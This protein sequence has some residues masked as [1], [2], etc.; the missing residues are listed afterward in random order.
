[1]AR[2]MWGGLRLA[3]IP[4]LSFVPVCR[5]H[6]AVPAAVRSRRLGIDNGSKYWDKFYKHHQNKFFKDR[7]YLEKDWGQYF[8]CDDENTTLPHGKV[9][10]EVGCGAGNTIFP[11]VARYPKLFV[12][13]CDFSTHAIKLLTSHVDFNEEQVNAFVCD[14]VEDDLCDKVMPSSV[15]VATLIFMLSA[16][17]PKKMHMILQNIRKVLKPEGYILVR[18]YAIGDY[19]QMELQKRNQLISENFYVRGDGTCAYFFSED[20]LSALFASVGFSIINMEIYSRKIQNR[21]QNVTM[22]R[23]WIRAAFGQVGNGVLQ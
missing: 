18:D 2:E 13:A 22:S 12:H 4:E 21:S 7:H 15:D 6:S 16:V 8:R 10:L 17:C 9:V 14:V 5:R 19:A 11:L 23:L 20:F 1:M 3:A